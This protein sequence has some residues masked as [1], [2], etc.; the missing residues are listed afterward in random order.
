MPMSATPGSPTKPLHDPIAPP[1]RDPPN[2]PMHDPPGDPT[3]E[4]PQPLTEP[5]PIQQVIRL[6][7]RRAILRR[8]AAGGEDC[9]RSIPAVTA[10]GPR[11]Y[12]SQSSAANYPPDQLAKTAAGRRQKKM[13]A[14]KPATLTLAPKNSRSCG[15][16]NSTYRAYISCAG[17]FFESSC[18]YM[19]VKISVAHHRHATINPV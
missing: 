3:F 4:P 17:C 6:L 9:R 12:A 16:A 18:I 15:G 14:P 19:M 1:E 13:M 10:P 7:K 2:K 8:C 5:T 11:P